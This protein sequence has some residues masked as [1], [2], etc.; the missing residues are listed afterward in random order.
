MEI[1]DYVYVRVWEDD[2]QS[3][4]TLAMEKAHNVILYAISGVNFITLFCDEIDA[5]VSND[6]T[7]NVN[8]TYLKYY[9]LHRGSHYD[10][11]FKRFDRGAEKWVCL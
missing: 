11:Y 9:L 1:G 8:N 3:I 5:H 2:P 10:Y 4:Y 6:V 7:L